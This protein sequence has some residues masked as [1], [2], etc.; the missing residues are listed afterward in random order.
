MAKGPARKFD[1][2]QIASLL[3]A[4]LSRADVAQQIGCSVWL[5]HEVGRANGIDRRVKY[6]QAKIVRLLKSGLTQTQVAKRI[7]CCS[8]WVCLIAKAHGLAPHQQTGIEGVTSLLVPKIIEGLKNGESRDQI[9]ANLGV[10]VSKVSYH[11]KRHGFRKNKFTPRP[12]RRKS[13]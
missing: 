9:A 11:A 5:V 7:G 8:E 4:G 1:H 12:G 13:G 3:R 2:E 6:D 10:S